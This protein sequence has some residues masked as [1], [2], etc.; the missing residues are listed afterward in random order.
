MG[1]NPAGIPAGFF[2]PVAKKNTLNSP[3]DLKY[4]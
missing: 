1:M 2:N 4:D 3:D